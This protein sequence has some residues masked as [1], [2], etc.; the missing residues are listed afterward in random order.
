MEISSMHAQHA[1]GIVIRSG[2]KRKLFRSFGGEKM[3]LTRKEVVA[4]L[5]AAA[6][7]PSQ[8]EI[9][10]ISP[11]SDVE[12]SPI[13]SKN[14]FGRS[15]KFSL[16]GLAEKSP[17]KSKDYGK[18][19]SNKK[20]GKNNDEMRTYKGE[21][22]DSSPIAGSSTEGRCFSNQAGVVFRYGCC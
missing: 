17:M 15:L 10:S 19:S 6:G 4:S 16:K 20:Y 18:K 21:E 3:K 11:Y 14:E 5:R 7:L 12:D 13:V 1:Q 22:P 9:F 8:E 2:I